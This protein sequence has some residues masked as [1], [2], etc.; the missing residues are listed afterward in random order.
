MK[1]TNPPTWRDYTDQLTADQIGSL[2]HAETRLSPPVAGHPQGVAALAALAREMAE[3]NAVDARYA[4]LAL[5]AGAIA[6]DG[7]TRHGDDGEWVRLIEWAVIP[8]HTPA[9]DIC[10]DGRQAT[11][12]TFTR[13]VAVYAEDVRLT[14]AQARDLAAAL[15]AAADEL[16]RLD[17]QEAGK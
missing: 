5:P 15:I 8:T 1:T 9:V 16:D 13:Q 4:G 2:E 7:W 11:D 17:R 14:A 3:T 6:N 10:V 12:G